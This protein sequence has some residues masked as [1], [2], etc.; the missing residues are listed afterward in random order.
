MGGRSTTVREVVRTF[1]GLTMWQKGFSTKHA[2]GHIG[3]DS[4]EPGNFSLGWMICFQH[5]EYHL[6]GDL[7]CF[8]FSIYYSREAF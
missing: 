6:H 1:V 5:G 2:S 7:S 4:S 8:H 3:W